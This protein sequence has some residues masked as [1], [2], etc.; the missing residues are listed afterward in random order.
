VH[1]Q[2]SRALVLSQFDLLAIKSGRQPIIPS[3]ERKPDL[4]RW[5]RPMIGRWVA[6]KLQ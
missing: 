4:L 3:F 5:D 1:R 6:P 2:A